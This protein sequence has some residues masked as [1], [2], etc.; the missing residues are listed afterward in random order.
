M[1]SGGYSNY[2]H[3]ILS[4]TESEVAS[5][6]KKVDE[7]YYQLDEYYFELKERLIGV[8]N[9][10]LFEKDIEFFLVKMFKLDD[11]DD[12]EFNIINF[13]EQMKSL[14]DELFT[15]ISN[16]CNSEVVTKLQFK[17]DKLNDK[18]KQLQ[19]DNELYRSRFEKLSRELNTG[20]SKIEVESLNINYNNQ[21]YFSADKLIINDLMGDASHSGG[22]K[23]NNLS[24]SRSKNAIGDLSSRKLN[25]TALQYSLSNNNYSAQQSNNTNFSST[26]KNTQMT[27]NTANNR[28]FKK[29]NISSRLN[30][31]QSIKSQ[32]NLGSGALNHHQPSKSNLLGNT[33]IDFSANKQ[34]I[35]QIQYSTRVSVHPSKMKGCDQTR[36]LSGNSKIQR[37]VS[38]SK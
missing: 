20:R 28:N 19:E 8:I 6:K 24:T 12:S 10:N 1:S 23:S 16:S 31:S 13:I 32:I 4:N 33:G 15:Q 2:G 5:K 21:P 25:S 35:D 34:L 17:I 27:Y 9:L 14:N 37:K 3:S 26:T 7:I 30:D 22:G 38:N 29:L 36:D 18:V 11:K